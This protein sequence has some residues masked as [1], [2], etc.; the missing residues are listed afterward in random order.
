MKA[1]IQFSK[2]D[3]NKGWKINTELEII[4]AYPLTLQGD[5]VQIEL[6]NVSLSDFFSLL[7]NFQRRIFS[8]GHF[9][10]R[11]KKVVEH[12][13]LDVY[14]YGG[15]ER[16]FHVAG[17]TYDETCFTAIAY[18]YCWFSLSFQEQ[19]LQ[20]LVRKDMEKI[21]GRD[22]A[23]IRERM[24]THLLH[25]FS[26]MIEEIKKEMQDELKTLSNCSIEK[27]SE[28]GNCPSRK[29]QRKC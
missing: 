24:K 20:P 12:V 28:V 9:T 25:E 16:D 6:P 13:F 2:N 26:N 27:F 21:K 7:P 18:P 19:E 1:N 11:G 14:R 8:Q 17:T 15:E 4:Q 22:L 29:K 10:I 5:K 3:N 23:Y